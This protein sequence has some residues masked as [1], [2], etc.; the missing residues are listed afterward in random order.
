MGNEGRAAM[1]CR[2]GSWGTKT[3]NNIF[4]N[5]KP[6]SIEIDNTSIYHLDSSYS[7][8]NTVGYTDVQDGLK[9]LAATLP[10]GPKDHLRSYPGTGSEPIRPFEW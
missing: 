9:S 1:Q 4:I 2:N 6:S 8:I 5:D 10:E 3:R 7:V